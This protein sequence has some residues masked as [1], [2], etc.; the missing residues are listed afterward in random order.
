M[1]PRVSVAIPVFKELLRR[2]AAIRNEMPPLDARD[3]GLMSRRGRRGPMDAG[4][5][6]IDFT[7]LILAVT[8]LS[9]VNLFF[10]GVIG[11]Y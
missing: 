5:P 7:A 11:E 10:L 9:E 4:A 1:P 6:P 3:F 8:F 2:T